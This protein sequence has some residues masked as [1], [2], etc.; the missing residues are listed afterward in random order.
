MPPKAGRDLHTTSPEQVNEREK[1]EFSPVA[2]SPHHLFV[3][4]EQVQPA[5]IQDGVWEGVVLHLERQLLFKVGTKISRQR[6]Q[7]CD[8]SSIRQQQS[9]HI[10]P[11][12][13]LR[14]TAL[15]TA[16]NLAEAKQRRARCSTRQR[17]SYTSSEHPPARARCSKVTHYCNTTCCGTLRCSLACRKEHTSARKA[18]SL[19]CASLGRSLCQSRPSAAG[20]RFARFGLGPACTGELGQQGQDSGQVRL[21]RDVGRAAEAGGLTACGA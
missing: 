9:L 8:T 14:A 18:F 19:H 17:P 7:R 21:D 5:P 6:R 16:G 11:D 4:V 15:E 20:A 3:Q 1:R 13:P 12:A 2:A 10:M